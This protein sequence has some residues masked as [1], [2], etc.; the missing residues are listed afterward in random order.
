VLVYPPLPD[1][2]VRVWQTAEPAGDDVAW[3]AAVE[4]G[5]RANRPQA[6]TL[7]VADLPAGAEPRLEL[8]SGA[9]VAEVETAGGKAWAVTVPADVPAPFRAAV[10]ARLPGRPVVALPV[11]DV[12]FAGVPSGRTARWLAAGTAYRP[13]NPAGL[14]GAAAGDWPDRVPR[15]AGGAVWRADG[16]EP[17]RLA[18]AGPAEPRAEPADTPTPAEPDATPAAGF[19]LDP[20]AGR[21]LVAAGWVLGFG[22][23]GGLLA[24]GPRRLGP[25]LLVLLG[26]VASVVAGPAFLA[27]S[28]A[29]G[30]MRLGRL[31]GKLAGV[32]MR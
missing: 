14:W 2:S 23:V 29:G 10:A 5:L 3:R 17:V 12:L 18:A 15:P 1:R 11:V 8:P 6:F 25:E 19:R 22:L 21:W 28:A 13:A 20:D 4:V 24:R 26:V 16:G 32:V 27:V 9:A 31:G 30:L 7:R